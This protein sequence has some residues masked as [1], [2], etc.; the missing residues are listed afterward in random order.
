[1]T[2]LTACRVPA[3][4]V[5]ALVLLATTAALFGI[6]RY[7][8]PILTETY[9]SRSTRF[10][11]TGGAVLSLLGNLWAVL[12][13]IA[14]MFRFSQLVTTTLFALSSGAFLI[15]L[16]HLGRTSRGGHFA[17]RPGRR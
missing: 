2:A 17:S 4:V 16:L 13:D 5:T 7:T 11:G 14:L 9:T 3:G 15:L 8:L 10:H 12:F 6:N 1:M